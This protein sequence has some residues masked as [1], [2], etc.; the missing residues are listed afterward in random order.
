MFNA[1]TVGAMLDAGFDLWAECYRERCRHSAKLD[2]AMLATRLG[3]EHSTLRKDLCPHL[4]CG[5]CGGSDVGVWTSGG[6][7]RTNGASKA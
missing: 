4:R 2:L 3:R 1:S 5:R 7:S 6:G